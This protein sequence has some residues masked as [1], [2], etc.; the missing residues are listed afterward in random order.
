MQRLLDMR[1]VPKDTN[2]HQV[3]QQALLMAQEGLAIGHNII[4][5]QLDAIEKNRTCTLEADPG[6]QRMEGYYEIRVGCHR[7]KQNLG[8]G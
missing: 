1:V 5:K 8:A 7:E 6:Y 2:S 4:K 3:I